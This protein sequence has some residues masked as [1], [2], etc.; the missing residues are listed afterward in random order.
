LY[1]YYCIYAGYCVLDVVFV[2]DLSG[3]ILTKEPPGVDNLELIKGFLNDTVG[4][5]QVDVYYDHIGLITFESSAFIQFTLLQGQTRNQVL[6]GISLLPTPSGNTNTPAALEM[7][8][9]VGI[10]CSDIIEYAV[11]YISLARMLCH[12]N[13]NAI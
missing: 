4:D 11:T 3:S 9:N 1:K 8:R 7:A 10:I 13:H 5:L 12:Q 2:V 6:S